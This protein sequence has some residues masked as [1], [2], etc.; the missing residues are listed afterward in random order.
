MLILT[1]TLPAALLLG[2]ALARVLRAEEAVVTA[3]LA[4]VA[5]RNAAQLD[6][7]LRERREFLRRLAAGPALRGLL[8]G[9]CGP[10]L[11]EFTRLHPE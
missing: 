6:V 2:W 10:P 5:E 4:A 11:Q 8:A 3:R 1:I 9:N 7:A